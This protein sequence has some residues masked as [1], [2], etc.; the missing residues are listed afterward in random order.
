MTA[1]F[2]KEFKRSEFSDF[3]LVEDSS[4]PTL[5]SS[6]SKAEN[7]KAT[8]SPAPTPANSQ[9]MAI[10]FW[11]FFVAI[12]ILVIASLVKIITKHNHKEANQDMEDGLIPSL[13]RHSSIRRD[14]KEFDESIQSKT[15]LHA[16][17]VRVPHRMESDDSILSF[18]TSSDVPKLLG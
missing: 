1:E 9:G 18:N 14:S 13:G 6:F 15:E 5:T 7:T 2:W 11:I 12:L 4:T 16:Q 10:F 17:G 3:A 8:P